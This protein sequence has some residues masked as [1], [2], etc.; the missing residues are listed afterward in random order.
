MA[1]Q[2]SKNRFISVTRLIMQIP[3]FL[4]YLLHLRKIVCTMYT[5]LKI[6]EYSRQVLLV[7]SGC[8]RY[9]FLSPRQARHSQ[10]NF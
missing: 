5:G 1:I 8:L 3:V 6:V 10:D 7:H 2:Y 9:F 4:T